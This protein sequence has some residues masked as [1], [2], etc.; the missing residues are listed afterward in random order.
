[1][2]CLS[3]GYPDR[4]NELEI[5]NRHRAGQPMDALTASASASQVQELQR[6]VQTVV[7]ETSLAEYM[8]EIISRTRSNNELTLGV[9]TRGVLTWYRAAQAMALVSEREYVIPDDI[10]DTAL[11]VL[12]HRVVCRG[13]LREGH[14][15]R[16]SQILRMIIDSVAVPT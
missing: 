14:R 2:M 9:S 6:Q 8:L 13:A 10:K 15:Q 5:L 12:A 11:P 3:L 7:V 4:K 16:A 1:M